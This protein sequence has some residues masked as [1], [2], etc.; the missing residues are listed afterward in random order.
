[1]YSPPSSINA[2]LLDIEG[3]TTPID[4]VHKVLFPYARAKIGEFVAANRA[5]LSTEI[6]QLETESLNDRD[7]EDHLDTTSPASISSYLRFLIDADRKST[8]LKTI[9][10]RIWKDGYESGELRSIVYGDVPT[11]FERW[12][13]EGKVIAIYSSGSVLAQKLI[14]HHSDHG[15]LTRFITAYFD[16]GIGAK[17]EVTSYENISRELGKK[18]SEIKFFSDIEAELDAACAAGLQ[19][20]LVDR[21]RKQRADITANHELIANF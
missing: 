10:G 20:A 14:F 12:H 18:P 7:F 21:S 6:S 13:L 9:Q 17:R 4:F 3:T 19:T 15:D 11:A 8:P 2:I 5:S 16:T 1:M